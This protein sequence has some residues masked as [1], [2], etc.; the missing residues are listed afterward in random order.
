MIFYVDEFE[1]SNFSNT[2]DG[3]NIFVKTDALD[4]F[5]ENIA[6]KIKNRY[7]LYS[8][9]SDI[10][11]TERYLKYIENNFLLN[12]WFAQN[13]NVNHEKLIP[14]PLGI[15]NAPIFSLW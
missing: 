7:N 12:R 10:N 11:I 9:N 5:F 3:M 13:V 4:F 6:N 1:V 15:A 8:H 14:I 2:F